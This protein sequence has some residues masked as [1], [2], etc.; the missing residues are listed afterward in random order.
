MACGIFF[1]YSMNLLFF[2]ATP[3]VTLRLILAAPA[4]PALLLMVAVYFVPE[5]PRFYLRPHRGR[6]NPEKAYRELRRL[7]TTEVRRP[8]SCFF[9]FF[10][11]FLR[12][13]NGKYP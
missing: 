11:F 10:F 8:V 2:L 13:S 7:R 6:Y 9:F 4:I 3:L 5:S 12:K 1:S